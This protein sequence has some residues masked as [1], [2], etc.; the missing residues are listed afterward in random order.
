MEGIMMN[1]GFQKWILLALISLPSVMAKA[2]TPP[3]PPEQPAAANSAD[4]PAITLPA[5]THMLVMLKSPLHTTSAENGA[6]V[7]S[8]TASVVVQNKRVVI[9]LKTQGQGIVESEQRP[10]R[11]KGKARFLLHFNTLTFSN[12]YTVPM[13]AALHSVPGSNQL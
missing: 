5:G 2:Q 10:G 3:A 6:G 12:N 4:P 7:Y 13:D 1:H 8:E 9:P 11:I